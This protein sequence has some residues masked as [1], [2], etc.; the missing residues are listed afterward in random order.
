LEETAVLSLISPPTGDAHLLSAVG[1]IGGFRHLDFG[2]STKAYDTP[3]FGTTI[4]IDFAELAPLTVVR[5]GNP[6]GSWTQHFAISSD[7]GVSWRPSG[8]EPTGLTGPGSDE[9]A[10]AVSADGSQ[11]LW[12]PGGAAVSRTADGGQTWTAVAGLPAG[13]SLRADRV[14]PSLFYAFSGGVFYRSTDGGRSFAAT[15][16]A[17]LPGTGNVRFKAV[18]GRRGDVWF[19]GGKAGGVYGLWRSTDAGDSFVRLPGVDEGDVVGFGMAAPGSSYPAVYT[20]ARIRGVRGLF[21]SDDAGRHWVRINDDRHQYGWTGSTLT[22]DPRVHGR[23]Y[24]GTNGRGII[25]GDLA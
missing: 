18:P 15:G 1:D 17:G 23:V 24:V 10:I 25:V 22:G 16:A 6:S 11:V 4:A 13:A 7:G 19:A 3:T 9:N 20:S 14:D 12:A 8:T 5:V 2:A 21:R